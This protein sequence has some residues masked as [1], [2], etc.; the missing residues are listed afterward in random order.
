MPHL[1]HSIKRLPSLLYVQYCNP[2]AYPPLEHSS[3]IMAR[4]GWK[5]VF[6]GTG[7]LREADSLDLPP[8]PNI[9][10]HRLPFVPGGWRQKLHYAGFALKVLQVAFRTRPKWI[11]ASDSL[12]C[13]LALLFTL[14][15]KLRVLY[16]EHD[17]PTFDR[18]SESG[19]FMRMVYL[20]RR[21]L[22][23]RADLCVL[24]NKGRADH[25]IRQ[26]ETSKLV[27]SVWNCPRRGEI[28]T[29]SKAADSVVVVFYHGTIVPGRLPLALV[30]A[31]TQ[32]PTSVVLLFAGYETV[33]NPG[34]IR[35]LMDEAVRWGVSERVQYL[36]A[37][38]RADLLRK[39]A[40]ADIGVSFMPLESLDVNERTMAGASN[41][42]FDYLAC[43]LALL[44]SDLPEWKRIFV[45]PGYGL[46]C[47]PEDS[48]AIAGALRWYL[49]NPEQLRDMGAR[50]RDRVRREWNYETQFQPVQELLSSTV[51]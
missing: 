31:L 36:G 11:Y 6:V 40:A 21:L 39:C 4:N 37:V 44:V 51:K 2:A 43:G 28:L 17:T 19:I 16:H 35:K 32:L 30:G 1:D 26:T 24:P 10:V 29:E 47:D 42:A 9:T 18:G 49:D 23:R 5:V 7:A 3:L 41:K 38:P 27:L 15:P 34:Y 46:A 25:F 50:G 12:S 48:R 13:P 8:H 20:A 22:A 45:E 14:H 33:G